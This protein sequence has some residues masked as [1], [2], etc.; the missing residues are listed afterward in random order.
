MLHIYSVNASSCMPLLSQNKGFSMAAPLHSKLNSTGLFYFIIVETVVRFFCCWETS[1]SQL[2]YKIGSVG[3][4]HAW[5]PSCNRKVKFLTFS[6]AP[7]DLISE[8][9]C[10]VVNSE[11]RIFFCSHLNYA[12]LLIKKGHSVG[13]QSP[14]LS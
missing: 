8:T 11:W 10:T 14:S 12:C 6:V 3:L 2:V 5:Q 1:A 13:Q 9:Y 4:D 7:I